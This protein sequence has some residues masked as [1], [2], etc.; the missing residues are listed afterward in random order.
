MAAYSL[1]PCR[2]DA[3][4]LGVLLALFAR[5]GIQINY[6]RP[7]VILLLL[8]MGLMTFKNWTIGTAPASIWGYSVTALF[9]T[10]L[11]SLV[12]QGTFSRIFRMSWLRWLGT[13]AYGIYLFHQPI[14]G[15]VHYVFFRHAPQMATFMEFLANLFALLL[16][17][18]LSWLSWLYFEKPLVERGHS[19]RY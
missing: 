8:L 2:A 10:C 13:I 19:Y 14:Q 16:T 1:M 17:I 12:L 11:V 4:M 7:L 6:L 5:K 18:G 9:Y 15:L 3:L